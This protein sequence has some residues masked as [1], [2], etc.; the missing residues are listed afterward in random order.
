MKDSLE[1]KVITSIPAHRKMILLTG[2]YA[3]DQ[4][5]ASLQPQFTACHVLY[6]RYLLRA[7]LAVVT[8]AKLYRLQRKFCPSEHCGFWLK[9]TKTS[10]LNAKLCLLYKTLQKSNGKEFTCAGTESFKCSSVSACH[11]TSSSPALSWAPSTRKE[12]LS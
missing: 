1:K 3:Y 4:H 7:N 6:T 12:P 9:K 10:N 11:C 8:H 2:Q 5:L